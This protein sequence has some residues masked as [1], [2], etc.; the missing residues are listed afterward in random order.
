[1]ATKEYKSLISDKLKDPILRRNLG[2]F[3]D[4]YLESRRKAYAAKDF[5]GIREAIKKAKSYSVDNLEEMSAKFTAKAQELGATVYHAKDGDDVKR[6]IAELAKS[7]NVKTIVKSKSMASEEIHLNEYLE[8]EGLVPV[9]TDLGEWI[10]QLAGHKPSHMVMPAIHMSREQ[11]AEVFSKELGREIPVDIK[12]MV[13]TARAELRDKFVQA[14]M[15]ISGANIAIAETGTIALV[16]NEGNARITSSIPQIH[17]VLV[18]YEKLVPTF[19]DAT[20]ILEALPRSATGQQLT[21]YVSL[22]TGPTKTMLQDGTLVDKE[23]HIIFIDNGRKEMAKDPLFKEAYQCIRCGSCLNVC[24]VY[25]LVGGH[26]Y[27]RIYA[28]GIGVI[29]TA[30]MEGLEAV[31]DLQELCVACGRCKE[32]CPGKVP[33]TD[34]IVEVR[35]RLFNKRKLPFKARAIFDNIMGNRKLFHTALRAAAIGAKPL[36]MGAPMM[37]HLPLY[38]LTEYRSLPALAATP[39][40]DR[41]GNIQQKVENR[42]GKVAYFSGCATD[43]AYPQIGE[44]LIKVLNRIG[45]E[46]VFP[47]EQTCCGTPPRYMGDLVT[48]KKLGKTNIEAFEAANADF[49]ITACPTCAGAWLHD[50]EGVFKDEPEWQERAKKLAEK[51]REFTSFIVK[52]GYIEEVGE[53]VK[54]LKVTYH[55]S[56]HLKRN[57]KITEEPRQLISMNSELI[58]MKYPDRCC[59]CGGSFSLKFP[60]LAAPIM[61]GKLADIEGTGADVVAMACPGCLLQIKGGLDKKKSK[62]QAKHIAEMLAEKL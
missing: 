12:A 41:V 11:V 18:G 21:S 37:R 16:S 9:E 8:S 54:D 46:V 39:L 60:E 7:R 15:G 38:G 6:Y 59:G 50:Y 25:Q 51:T 19:K 30:Y 29:L 1:M 28:G 13:E 48:A 56:C 57:L 24:P 44:A 33:I 61:E 45:Y 10:I 62:V 53:Q 23:M 3:A 31:D 43:F 14:E 34:L 58:E 32:V 47:E 49:L 36:T 2:N 35:D 40:R 20:P 52:E 5:E 4:A 17:V 27:G 26:V 42:R 55:D 22:V